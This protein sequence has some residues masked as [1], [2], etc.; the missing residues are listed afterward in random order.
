MKRESTTVCCSRLIN[1]VLFAC[2][3][4][5][6][7]FYKYIDMEYGIWSPM[8]GMAKAIA[9]LLPQI[10][11]YPDTQYEVTFIY[12]S[13]FMLLLVFNVC[14]FFFICLS[15]SFSHT[16]LHSV[17]SARFVLCNRMVFNLKH[18]CAYRSVFAVNALYVLYGLSFVYIAHFFFLC[19]PFP[20][21][22]ALC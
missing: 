6:I 16:L 5:Y 18:I 15:L 17:H 4:L 3:C 10:S 12:A 20:L 19:S 7:Q 22:Q 21:I 13:F 8:T 11:K 1:L 2:R 14:F 9:I